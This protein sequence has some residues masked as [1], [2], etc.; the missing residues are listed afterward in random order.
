MRQLPIDRTRAVVIE[1]IAII[2]FGKSDG[3]K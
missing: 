1:M 2:L 3:G